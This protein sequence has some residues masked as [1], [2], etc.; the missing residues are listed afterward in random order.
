MKKYKII[1]IIHLNTFHTYVLDSVKC[2]YSNAKSCV[3]KDKLMSEYFPCNIGVRQ[4][5]NLSPLLFSLFV[6]DFSQH[7]STSY[8]GINIANSCYPS[9]FSEDVVLL[10]LFVLL[11]ADDTIVLSENEHELQKAL[12]SVHD[13]CEMH[14]LIVNTSKTKIVVFSRGKVKRFP[15]FKYGSDTIE[16]VS[17]YVYLGIKMN[18]NN[19][20]GKAIK[21]QL[22]Q[23]RKAKFAL[24]VKARKLNLPIDI[25]CNLF[26]KIVFPT[27]LYGCEIWGFTGID[28][29]E[30]FYKKFLKQSLK[31]RPSTPNCM[32]YGEV[33]KLPLQVTVD[34]LLIAY[35]LR[36]LNKDECTLAHIVYMITF[37]LFVRG[38]YKSK[39]LS[40]AKY[41]L[42]Y[43]GLSYIWNDQSTIDTY[44]CKQIIQ[45]RIEDI[46]LHKWFSE[47]STSSMCSTY[48]LFKKELNFEGY[49]M[50]PNYKNRISLTKFR[51]SNTK[52]P[53]YNQIY[54]YDTDICN[55]CSL[56]ARGDEFHYI[57]ICP[58]FTDSRTLYLKPYFN[59]RSNSVKFEQLFNSSNKTTL[60]RLAK[61]TNVILNQL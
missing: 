48:R 30:T 7:I 61:F 11:Y 35:W 6:N 36:L 3:R 21:K 4:G 15:M 55:L 38:E 14:K 29:L 54:L 12:N 44:H 26:E 9:L 16:V 59:N 18:Y 51:C 57:F 33:G 24:L 13:Y 52:M 22:D 41:I 1:I 27:L 50:N 31:L 25:Q 10:K 37:N 49:L 23:G 2:L 46:A 42:D 45:K 32:V 47:V 60:S 20:F 40:R 17:D 34:K 56:G 19:T 28:M 58:F 43:C 39:W 53:V 5:D 8:Q